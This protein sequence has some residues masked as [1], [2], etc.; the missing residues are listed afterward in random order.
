MRW[1]DEIES[2]LGVHWSSSC[3][4]LHH[5]SESK[6][7]DA[8]SRYSKPTLQMASNRKTIATPQISVLWFMKL[9]T[10]E[11]PRRVHE[12]VRHKSGLVV[13]LRSNVAS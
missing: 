3:R 8:L 13:Y 9:F 11:D 5:H 1:R 12:L 6:D 10:V 7:G 4:E 2:G